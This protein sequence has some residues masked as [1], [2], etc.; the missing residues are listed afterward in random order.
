MAKSKSKDE[1]TPKKSNTEQLT[2]STYSFLIHI[3]IYFILGVK[4]VYMKETFQQ[5]DYTYD[6][7]NAINSSSDNAAAF[8]NASFY[9]NMFN[10]IIY[11]LESNND[12]C[13]IFGIN[14]AATP[15]Y[16]KN[17]DYIDVITLTQITY[18]KLLQYVL[19]KLDTPLLIM[20]LSPF[21]L[22]GVTIVFIF[23][24]VY[25]WFSY[26]SKTTIWCTVYIFLF[27]AWIYF[28][29]L[30][31]I[32]TLLIYP[33]KEDVKPLDRHGNP[34]HTFGLTYIRD[35]MSRTYFK[36]VIIILINLH[37]IKMCTSFTPTNILIVVVILIVTF[38]STFKG[39]EMFPS[40][41]NPTTP[42][43]DVQ[44]KRAEFQK[45]LNPQLGLGWVPV[46]QEIF[47]N[48][49]GKK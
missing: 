34:F 41:I 36:Y 8:N 49:I 22:M 24:Y 31:G 28:S 6:I 42:S 12:S 18:L 25:M 11:K 35:L 15:I 47:D 7:T 3:C 20:S 38:I 32:Y 39:Y 5:V 13:N 37:I 14:L 10:N 40:Y 33:T 19:I 17:I 9:V 29:P 46:A 26:Y 27:F 16:G 1:N 30:I 48:F 45:A 2:S 43:D 21:I 23:Y 4:L 44:R